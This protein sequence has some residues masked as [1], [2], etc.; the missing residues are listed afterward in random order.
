M[1]SFQITSGIKIEIIRLSDYAY[2]ADYKQ[3]GL[4]MQG[5]YDNLKTH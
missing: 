5:K 2:A 4:K 1:F 3:I